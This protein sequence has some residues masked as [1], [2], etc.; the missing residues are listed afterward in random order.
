MNQVS[1]I[2][3]GNFNFTYSKYLQA[4]NISKFKTIMYNNL[5]INFTLII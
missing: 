3:E 5:R 2:S 4:L 1:M